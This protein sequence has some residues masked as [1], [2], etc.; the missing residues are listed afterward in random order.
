MEKK[1]S[2]G[3]TIL[4]WLEIL[5]GGI[6]SIFFV[7]SFYVY[8]HAIYLLKIGSNS[9]DQLGVDL[10][11]LFSVMTFPSLFIL[12]SGIGILRCSSWARK[13]NIVVIPL[14]LILVTVFLSQGALWEI[15]RGNLWAGTTI[16]GLFL[17]IG[18]VIFL[19]VWYLTRPK[20][21]EQFK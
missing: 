7:L 13:M 10:G 18:I 12:V 8:L 17:A 20:V 3:V 15:R 11:F 14:V 19:K 16:L 6:G 21:K 5:I 1:R 2:V 4:G 9:G